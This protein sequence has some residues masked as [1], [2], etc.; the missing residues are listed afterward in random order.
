MNVR[1]TF[2]ILA[3]AAGALAAV[4]PALAEPMGGSVAVA[5]SETTGT[6]E[7]TADV[8]LGLLEAARIEPL[9]QIV[10]TEGARHGLS[11]EGALFPGRGGRGWER[12]VSAIQSPSRLSDRVA[13]ILRAELSPDVARAARAYLES[14]LGA[15]VV[16]QEVSARR[17]MLDGGAESAAR[18]VS[19]GSLRDASPRALIIG[20]ILDRLDLVSVNVTGGLNANYALYRGLADGGAL[21]DDMTEGELVAMV[22]AQEEKLRDAT[23]GWLRSYLTLAYAP[24]SDD[25]LRAH[26]D[27]CTGEAGARYI[28]GLTRAFG[29]VFEETSYSLGRAAATFIVQQDA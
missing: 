20:E 11:L 22:W 4:A 17:G 18:S 1:M 10:A 25:D 13:E 16:N 5:T 24:L 19:A 28:A 7:T 8:Y 27:F 2:R 26:L 23:E 14:D 21:R 12:H 29:T 3:T 6:A 9:M 15:R